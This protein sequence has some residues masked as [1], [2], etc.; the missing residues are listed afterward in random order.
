EKEDA[1][2]ES[3]DPA[4]YGYCVF[5][6]IV[7]GLEVLDR[8]GGTPVVDKADFPRTPSTPVIIKKIE[9]LR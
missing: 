6:E 3:R 7:E 2:A 8:I 1:D 5:G 4:S 9:R